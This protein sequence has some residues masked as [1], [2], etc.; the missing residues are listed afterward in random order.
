MILPICRL[1]EQNLE[2]HHELIPNA[3]RK[4]IRIN[5]KTKTNEDLSER[6]PDITT[7]DSTSATRTTSE[8]L[9]SRRSWTSDTDYK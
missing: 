1:P 5:K 3:I 4:P 8:L 9:S 6:L 2:N 7:T